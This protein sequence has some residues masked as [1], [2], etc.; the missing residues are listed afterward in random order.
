MV[1]RDAASADL[2]SINAIYNHYVPRSTCT[3]DVDARSDDAAMRWLATHDATHP[4]TVAT[5][6]HGDVIAWGSL[7]PFRPRF[8]YRHTVEDTVYVRED[9]HGRGVGRAILDDLV[10]RARARGHH[11][12]IAVISADQAAS[13]RLHE[14]A[15]FTRVAHLPQ[16]G[17]KFDRWLDLTMLQLLL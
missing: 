9:Q 4:V 1:I 14:R 10:A 5:D 7:S 2:A 17:H 12:I 6:E 3:W 15:G 11:A 16:V 8:G 13:V